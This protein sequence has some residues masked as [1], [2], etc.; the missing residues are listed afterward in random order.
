MMEK[1]PLIPRAQQMYPLMEK[2]LSSQLTQR[3]FCQQEALSMSTFLYWLKRYRRNQQSDAQ[4]A[5]EFIP[6]HFTA[7]KGLPI[8]AQP[9]CAVEYPNGVVIRLF[10]SVNVQMVAQLVRMQGA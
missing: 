10:G 7:N 4:S 3:Q 1:S 5:R 8:P 2:Y 6:L 9:T